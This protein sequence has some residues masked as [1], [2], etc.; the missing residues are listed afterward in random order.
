M[1]RIIEEERIEGDLITEED[2]VFEKNC[3]ITG[4]VT[5][6]DIRAKG[7][8]IVIDTIQ[9]TEDIKVDGS[10]RAGNYFI[11]AGGFIQAG[12]D[13][14][15]GGYIEA[16]Y[17]SIQAEGHIASD[18]WIVAGSYIKAGEYISTGWTYKIFAGICAGEDQ[19]K[20]Q[21]IT[22][23]E[24]RGKIGHGIPKI[25]PTQGRQEES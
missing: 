12:G 17:D 24:I 25:I 16:E 11:K 8:L 5:A 23:K 21:K 15:A 2:V 22:A 18:K 4:R 3:L 1:P 10:I 7:D 9:A 20:K 13:I 19:T 6:K 14:E